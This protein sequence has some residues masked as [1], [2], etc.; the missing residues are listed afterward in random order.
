MTVGNL[1]FVRQNEQFT[2][3]SHARYL[4]T[5]LSKSQQYAIKKTN[6]WTL[7][8]TSEYK[9][10]VHVVAIETEVVS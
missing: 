5:A 8:T 7:I 10:D 2:H 1:G 3:E 4:Y 9:I 6:W